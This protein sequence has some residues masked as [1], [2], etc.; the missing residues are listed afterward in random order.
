MNLRE[1]FLLTTVLCSWNVHLL[2]IY[3]VQKRKRKR[4]RRWW[5]RPCNR[6]RNLEGAFE[7]IFLKYKQTDHEMFYKMTRLTVDLFDEL[8]EII[9][10]HIHK[11]SYREFLSPEFR[12]AFTIW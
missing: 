1:T 12:L 3:E 11:I 9:G 4:Y 7:K 8:L 10:P 5:V 6:L 2:Q